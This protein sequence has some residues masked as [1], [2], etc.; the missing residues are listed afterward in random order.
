VTAR[1]ALIFVKR[2]VTANLLENP[3]KTSQCH[4][5]GALIEP[6]NCHTTGWLWVAGSR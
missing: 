5:I 6:S 4:P 2:H 1:P 3:S